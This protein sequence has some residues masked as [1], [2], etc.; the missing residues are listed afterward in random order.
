MLTLFRPASGQVRAK[1]V[2]SSANSVL[3]P[4]L[5]SKLRTILATFD[6]Y[7]TP[8]L[9]LPGASLHKSNRPY[10]NIGDQSGSQRYCTV[11]PCKINQ[12]GYFPGSTGYPIHRKPTGNLASTFHGVKY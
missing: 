1:G 8:V 12:A 9:A 11:P 7:L 10:H 6:S 2:L 3:H 5:K 4:L